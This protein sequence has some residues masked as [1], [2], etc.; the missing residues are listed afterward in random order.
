MSTPLPL[1]TIDVIGRRLKAARIRRETTRER[2]ALSTRQKLPTPSPQGISLAQI[3]VQG[4]NQG[5]SSL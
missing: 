4:P 5:T 3:S 1:L 2:L